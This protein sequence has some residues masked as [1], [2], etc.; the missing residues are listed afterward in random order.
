EG[1]T[2]SS[3]FGKDLEVTRSGKVS[4]KRNT[5]GDI[6]DD[7]DI[8]GFVN[9][10]E[11]EKVK[12]VPV[13]IFLLT[14][15]NLKKKIDESLSTLHSEIK[16]KELLNKAWFKNQIEKNYTERVREET[17]DHIPFILKK[18]SDSLII[19]KQL[20]A[21]SVIE[22]CIREEASRCKHR[23]SGSISCKQD[24]VSR[25]IKLLETESGPSSSSYELVSKWC[26]IV[27]KRSL[28]LAI[29]LISKQYIFSADQEK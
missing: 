2:V 25:C 21:L 10:E 15:S 16:K 13:D 23:C 1:Q 9:L 12:S 4:F 28:V 14:L 27:F 5:S 19:K 3:L 11:I 24:A 18:V 8:K 17:E 22:R 26:S 20:H 6:G 7:F 29:Q